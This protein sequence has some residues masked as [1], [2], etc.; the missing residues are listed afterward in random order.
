MLSREKS[1][2]MILT[3]GEHSESSSDNS[4]PATL[5]GVRRVRST[6]SGTPSGTPKI[7]EPPNPPQNLKEPAAQR[8]KK[9]NLRLLKA[10][11]GSWRRWSWSGGGAWRP[12][13]ANTTS[14]ETTTTRASRSP[15]RPP[16]RLKET[17]ALGRRGGRS[18]QGR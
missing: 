10:D 3:N 15:W 6:P 17:P 1:P 16:S 8:F 14:A 2:S 11:D 18:H 5:E 13:S 7:H 4:L 12:G 9:G